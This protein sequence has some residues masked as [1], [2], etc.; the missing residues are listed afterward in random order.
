MKACEK[1]MS[2]R[3]EVQVVVAVIDSDDAIAVVVLSLQAQP[4]MSLPQR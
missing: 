1:V 3:K 4:V 2:C